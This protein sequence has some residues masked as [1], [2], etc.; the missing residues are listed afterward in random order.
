MITTVTEQAQKAG[1][2]A[3]KKAE[4][5]T[6][7]PKPDKP[8]L[9][10]EQESTDV[11]RNLVSSPPPRGIQR[12]KNPETDPHAIRLFNLD[13]NGQREKALIRIGDWFSF[14]SEPHKLLRIRAAQ[15]FGVESY[16]DLAEVETDGYLPISPRID[17]FLHLRRHTR[18]EALPNLHPH[19]FS[20]WYR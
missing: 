6:E 4:K 8:L 14:R 11:N 3:K 16:F 7:N 19:F 20:A 9:V 15:E 1:G 17:E 12:K 2:M 10:D 5:S 18:S 13:G